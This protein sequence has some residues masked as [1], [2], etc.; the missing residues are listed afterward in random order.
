V[1][2]DCDEILNTL[3]ICEQN[4]ADI[5]YY[6]ASGQSNSTQLRGRCV[7]DQSTEEH[8]EGIVG[9]ALKEV[10]CEKVGPQVEEPFLLIYRIVINGYGIWIGCGLDVC[11]T[12]TD[13]LGTL[14]VVNV[15]VLKCLLVFEYIYVFMSTKE[16]LKVRLLTVKANMM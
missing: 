7:S 11:L 8:K 10:G 2:K 12:L 13:H 16:R 4:A 5:E 15:Y 9:Y 6:E 1:A 14:C 3:Q